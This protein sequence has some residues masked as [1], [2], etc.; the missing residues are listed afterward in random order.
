MLD[1][2][3]CSPEPCATCRAGPG[4]KVQGYGENARRHRV[5]VLPSSI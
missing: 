1:S 2:L 5:P 4:S 3:V